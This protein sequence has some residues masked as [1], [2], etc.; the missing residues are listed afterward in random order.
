MTGNGHEDRPW[1]ASDGD[2]VDPG[3][4]PLT[5]H[6]AARTGEQQTA[7]PADRAWWE[8]A[9][10]AL[11]AAASQAGRNRRTSSPPPPHTHGGDTPACH[12]CPICIA[13]RA[14]SS[15]RPE[16]VAH[17]SEA[18]RQLSLAAKAFV[19]AQVEATGGTDSGLEHIS[20]D[21]E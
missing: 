11:Q 2:A 9:A 12:A 18:A 1:W 8:D 7:E 20:I 5:A 10:D 21:D 16:V 15:S 6:R 3:Q 19:D 17:L 14:L 13:I 4:D